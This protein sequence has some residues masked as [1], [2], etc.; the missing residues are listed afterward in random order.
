MEA[1][2]P[3]PVPALNP[4]GSLGL[5]I[6]RWWECPAHPR[7]SHSEGRAL[8]P[9]EVHAHSFAGEVTHTGPGSQAHPWELAHV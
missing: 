1:E 4:Q 8:G 7:F 2:S 3:R 9:Q 6:L 5:P